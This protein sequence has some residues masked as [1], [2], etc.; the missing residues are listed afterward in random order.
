MAVYTFVGGNANN[1]WGATAN[2]SSGIIP[3]GADTAVFNALSPTCGVNAGFGVA[4]L[5]C[6]NYG[7]TMTFTT[8]NSYLQIGVGMTL[9]TGMNMR[10]ATPVSEGTT[11]AEYPQTFVGIAIN[12]TGGGT[13]TFTTNGVVIPFFSSQSTSAT[14]VTLTLNG[15]CTISGSEYRYDRGGGN[16]ITVNGG[17][18]VLQSGWHWWRTN[19]AGSADFIMAPPLGATVTFF[20]E[21]NPVSSSN[22]ITNNL[23]FRGPGDFIHWGT[24]GKA[25]GTMT[26]V[27]GGIKTQL[28]NNFQYGTL[29]VSGGANITLGSSQWSNL[30]VSGGSTSNFLASNKFGNNASIGG[31]TIGGSG[32]IVLNGANAATCNYAISGAITHSSAILINGTGTR[33][34]TGN[35]TLSSGNLSIAMISGTANMLGVYTFSNNQQL[36]IFSPSFVNASLAT[37]QFSSATATPS[38]LNAAGITVGT[39]IAVANAKTLI[40]SPVYFNNLTSN[41]GSYFAGAQGWTA[42]NFTAAGN[43]TFRAGLTYSVGGVFTMAGSSPTARPG[44]F[45]D[46]RIDFTGTI[47]GS[48][49][50]LSAGTALPVGAI[51]SQ[52]SG[53]IPTGLAQLLP[54]RPSVVSGGP[55]AYTISPGLTTSIGPTAIAMAAGRPAYFTMLPG[56]SAPNLLWVTTQDINSIYGNPLF[57]SE[58]FNDTAGQPNPSLFRTLNWGALSA[59]G[60]PLARTFC[61]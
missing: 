2:W 60:L 55:T 11:A 48:V 44:L 22:L 42:T 58:S 35:S 7:A 23:I 20:C 59:P 31:S 57:P 41:A 16:S 61:S 43:T 10:L 51:V 12:T 50:T 39:G 53:L 56:S 15:T 9:G 49:L 6:T 25:G 34:L 1:A 45:S 27:G 26:Y 32:T 33:N 40:T 14:P 24:I 5:D 37:F 47:T 52:R 30:I 21:R 18:L 3:T 17:P 38:I 8:T 29:Q 19:V 36:N 4:N 13:R 28:K 54:G 46:T